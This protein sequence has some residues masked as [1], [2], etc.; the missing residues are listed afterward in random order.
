M[1]DRIEANQAGMASLIGAMSDAT[2]RIGATLATL[3]GDVAVLR[4]GFTGAASDA[5]DKAHREWLATLESM[6]TAL[7]DYTSAVQSS[8]EIFDQSERSGQKLW[9]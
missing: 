4:A 3:D 5:Y 7:G 6:Q 9:K 1:S 2:K 8:A